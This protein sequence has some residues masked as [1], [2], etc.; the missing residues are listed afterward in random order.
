LSDKICWICSG[1]GADTICSRCSKIVC[2][3][4]FDEENKICLECAEEVVDSRIKRKKIMLISGILL[5]VLGISTAAAGLILGLP[6]EGITVVFPF[7]IGNVSPF[8]AGLYSFLFFITIACA[9]LLPWYIH[10]HQ[11]NA[12]A[13]EDDIT[14]M[15]GKTM[16]G[17]PFEHVEYVITAELPKKLEKTILVETTDT[18]IHL[19]SSTDQEFKRIYKIPENHDLESF[20][21]DYDE[22]YLVLKLNLVRLP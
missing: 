9:S 2:R 5:I 4:C 12:Y 20:D 11:R 3:D 10:T 17:E 13:L 15:E 14:I 16:D 22:G 21:Y 7:I 6:T 8:T 1:E 19:H 18:A